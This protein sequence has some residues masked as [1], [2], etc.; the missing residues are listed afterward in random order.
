VGGGGGGDEHRELITHALHLIRDDRQTDG[1]GTL[2]T[3]AGSAVLPTIAILVQGNLEGRSSLHSKEEIVYR[4]SVLK[5]R[6][7]E[8]GASL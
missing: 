8:R 7:E 3:D 2:F 1:D 4:L 5:E 6:K